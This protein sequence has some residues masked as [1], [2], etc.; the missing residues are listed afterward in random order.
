ML[1]LQGHAGDSQRKVASIF[2]EAISHSP[3]ISQGRQEQGTKKRKKKNGKENETG[4]RLLVRATYFYISLALYS[5][6]RFISKSQS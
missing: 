5:S 2:L 1:I 6:F 4:E 3:D